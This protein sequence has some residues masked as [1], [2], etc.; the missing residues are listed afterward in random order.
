M[1]TLQEPQFRVQTVTA[2]LF[3]KYTGLRFYVLLCCSAYWLTSNGYMPPATYI[4]DSL[5]RQFSPTTTQPRT[6][7]PTTT[8]KIYSLP[9]LPHV[10]STT[11]PSTCPTNSTPPLHGDR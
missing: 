2:V 3:S 7:S 6:P 10:P 9:L 8:Q 4:I 5:P 11:H 1:Q